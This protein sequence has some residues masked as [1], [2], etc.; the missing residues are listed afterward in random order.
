[1]HKK[2]NK[3]LQFLIIVFMMIV[4]ISSGCQTNST[5][6]IETSFPAATS[7]SSLTTPN[8]PTSYSGDF[9]KIAWFYKPPMTEQYALIAKD[10]DVVILTNHDEQERDLIRA[11][12]L[13]API[14]QYLLLAEIQ[15]PG[16][17]QEIPNGNQVANRPGD[18][19][20]ISIDHPDWFLLDKFGQRVDNGDGYYYMDPGEPGFRAFWLERAR[21][22]QIEY[23][24]DGIFLDN[25]EASLLKYKQM[26]IGLEKYPDDTSLVTAVEEFLKYLDKNYFTPENRPVIA[27][28]ISLNDPQIWYRYLHYMDGAM[29]E[30]FAVDWHGYFS[31]N[32]WEEQMSLIS[33]TQEL[34]KTALL[35]SQGTQDDLQ[36]ENFSFASYLLIANGQTSFRYTH[37]SAYNQIWWYPDY[38]IDLGNPLSP[39]RKEDEAWTRDFENG[40]VIV[41]PSKHTGKIVIMP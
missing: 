6:T 16:S 28:I 29:L 20:E 19:C 35:V 8:N 34:G 15:D 41:N 37:H 7:T 33:T 17:C 39:M 24:W 36:K 26:F 23:K 3:F 13:S 14:Y 32:D 12:G 10:F 5:N 21:E 11:A 40:Q 4:T 9:I 38:E 27:N 25:V 2:N 1:M 18:F 22:I 30:N 31:R